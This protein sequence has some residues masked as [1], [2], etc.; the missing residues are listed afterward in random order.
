MKIVYLCENCNTIHSLKGWIFNC[1]ECNKE[2]CECCMYGWATCKECAVG[3][4]KEELEKRF[5][6][7]RV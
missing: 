2:I 3:K 7:E 6:E 5:E 4:T 1:V